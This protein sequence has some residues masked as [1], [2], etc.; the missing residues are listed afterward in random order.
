MTADDSNAPP[1]PKQLHRTILVLG[2][3]GGAIGLCSGLSFV[4]QHFGPILGAEVRSQSNLKQIGLAVH[5]YSGAERRMPGPFLDD[6][7]RDQF[8]IPEN[9]SDR[10]SWRVVVLPYIEA[11]PIYV[12][13]NKSEVWNSPTNGPLLD[14]H[15]STFADPLDGK[16]SFTPY[17]VFYDNGALWDSDPK[18][19]LA[20][21]KVPD[22]S[23]NTILVV[24]STVQVPW[25][26]FNEHPYGPNGSLPELGRA[27]RNTFIVVMVDGS[28]RTVKKTVNPAT[29]NAA[30]TRA[31]NDTVGTD[32]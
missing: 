2:L 30:I 21:D 7:A 27:S 3:I 5:T 23:S 17:R 15:R 22:G 28:V 25:A 20:L 32:W 1:K 12:K 19:R 18:R 29:L 6:H 10:L 31:G 16:T 26:Q 11:S 8:P 13:I 24:E 9:P 14:H 4:F